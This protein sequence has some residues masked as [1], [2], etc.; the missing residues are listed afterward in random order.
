MILT[1]AEAN[2]IEAR[3]AKVEA[4]TGAQVV[5]AVVGKS[6]TYPQLPWKAFALGAA[7]AG[8][9][10]VLADWLRPDWTIGYAALL[11]AVAILGAGAT[12]A[13]LVVFVPAFARLFLRPPRRDLEVRR[14]AE[15]L[16]LKRE[17][18]GTRERNGVLLL[19]SLFERR[20]EIVQDVGFRGRVSAAEWH[21]AIARM[22]PLLHAGRPAEAVQ[23]G[24][25]AIELLL[26]AKGF[27]AQP[28]ERNELPDRP[29][30]ERGP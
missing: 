3:V 26:T 8:F 28:G 27:S 5:A 18:F 22:T 24:L 12:F 15:S 1:P 6:N 13:L 4:R 11:H 30:E 10:V 20:V 21:Q 25:A 19:V 14:H 16:F 29:I 7:V 9:G 17:L 23:E 2:A